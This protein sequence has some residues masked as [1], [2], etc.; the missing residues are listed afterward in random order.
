MGNNSIS[1]GVTLPR[2]LKIVAYLQWAFWVALAVFV[3]FQP[4]LSTTTK[5]AACAV[6]LLAGF[7]VGK[8]FLR[9]ALA[10]T[11]KGE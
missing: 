5:A 4:E 6:F 2:A 10:M 3:L 11:N 9:L 7:L 1:G 8:A